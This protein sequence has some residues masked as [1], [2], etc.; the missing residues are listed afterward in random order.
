MVYV[1]KKCPDC[2][3]L[4]QNHKVDTAGSS[5]D[6]G[7]PFE[8]C[9]NCKKYMVNPKRK[10]VNMLTTTDWLVMIS[11]EIIIGIMLA[12]FVGIIATFLIGKI[13]NF[14]DEQMQTSWI[15]FIIMIS[16]IYYKNSFIGF[17]NKINESKERLKNKKYAKLVDEIINK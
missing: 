9:P 13:F 10:E 3:Y 7:Y 1:T 11:K 15:I 4:I 14:S 16:I 12:A 17:K 6:I 5:L 2:G 8:Q